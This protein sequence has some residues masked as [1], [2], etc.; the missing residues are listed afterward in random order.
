MRQQTAALFLVATALFV[1]MGCASE[2]PRGLPGGSALVAEGGGP[3]VFT[4]PDKGT[5]YVYD[6]RAHHV[7]FQ[8]AVEKG[9][10]LEIDPIGNQVTLDGRQVSTSALHS[11]VSYQI[12]MK[13]AEQREYHPM[14]NP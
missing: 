2:G 14:M 10:R 3:L 4:A 5:L 9:Q 6:P 7:V 13:V 11:N 12:F 1:S 8:C